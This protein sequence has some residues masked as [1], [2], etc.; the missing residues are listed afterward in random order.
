MQEIQQQSQPKKPFGKIRN[1]LWPIYNYELKKLI[2]MFTLFFL[3][4]FVYNVLR[5]MKIAIVVTAKGSGAEIISFLKIFG[6]LPGA[7]VLTYIYTTLISRFSREQVFYTMLAGFLLYFAFFMM[8]LYPNHDKL[9]LDFLANYLQS[10]WFVGP[11]SKG[12]ISVIRHLNLSIF[13]VLTEMWSSV[14]LSTLFWGF[15]NEVTKIDEAK[16]FYAVFALG[17]NSSGVFC[18]LFA[19][20][21]RKI[22]YN[23]LL[24]FDEANQWVFYHLSFVLF[25]GVVIIGLFYWLNRSVFHLENVQSL[26]IPKKSTKISLTECFKYL[27]SSKY[28]TYIVIIVISYNIVYNLADIMWTA[29]IKQVYQSSKDFNA[30]MSQ[31]GLV[32]G[33][34]AVLFTFVISGNVIRYYGWTI[35]A[36]ITPVIWLLTSIGVFSELVLDGTVVM[37]LIVGWVSNPLNLFLLLGSIQICLG[38]SCKYTVFDETKEISFIPLSKQ[39]QRKSKAVVD[40]LASRF[41]KSGGSLIYIVLFMFVGDVASAVPYVAVI[42]F[43][44][45]IM[46]IY[47]VFG[48]GKIIDSVIHEPDPKI[49][50][51]IDDLYVEN[52]EK[53]LDPN[54]KPTNNLKQNINSNDL[55][56]LTVAM[57]PSK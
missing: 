8:F 25:L 38:R 48:L 15:A 42:M 12:F 20:F 33:I 50:P 7:L 39:N 21:I 47:A 26:K 40:G 54:N 52:V 53:T 37:N 55:P 1:F 10:N 34:L 45:I 49:E 3:I 51:D 28:L 27:V 43:I 29:K 32:T 18:G 23:P 14:V 31:V 30:Y 5:I 22:A 16:R 19:Q 4:T 36:L 6:V 2:P 11:G 44:A 9:Q 13:Y 57:I 17:A 56:R 41:G 35:T 24:P 46:W